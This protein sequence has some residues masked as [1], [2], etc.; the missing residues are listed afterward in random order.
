MKLLLLLFLHLIS[1]SFFTEAN[2]CLDD[3]E[4]DDDDSITIK[5][6]AKGGKPIN[7]ECNTCK[8]QPYYR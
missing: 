4:Y 7:F 5:Y 2:S 8:E 3:I 1:Y 6:V